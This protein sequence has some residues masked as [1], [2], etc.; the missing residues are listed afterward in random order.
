MLMVGPDG[1]ETIND[2]HGVAVGDIVLRI[3]ARRLQGAVADEPMLI[4]RW[5]RSEFLAAGV[6]IDATAASALA[7]RLRHVVS[8]Y[9]FAIGDGHSIPVTVSVGCASGYLAT[10]GAV[11][12]AAESTWRAAS[13][14][15]GDRVVTA[16]LTTNP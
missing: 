16:S 14:D 9:P 15:G 7:E 6:G 4:C 5:D 2:V 10:C 1:F 3:A 8:M 13:Q 12:R 11:L